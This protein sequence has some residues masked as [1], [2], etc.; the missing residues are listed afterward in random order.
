MFVIK[1]IGHSKEKKKEHGGLLTELSSFI[2]TANS[3]PKRWW[4]FYS[5]CSQTWVQVTLFMTYSTMNFPSSNFLVIVL[6]FSFHSWCWTNSPSVK[7]QTVWVFLPSAV[8]SSNF[9]SRLQ[10][11]YT[12]CKV[13]TV[14][15]VR[16]LPEEE[17][18]LSGLAVAPTFCR[19]IPTLTSFNAFALH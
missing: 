11:N 19:A 14:F 3:C 10:E 16:C 8:V 7:L 2:L 18:I 17:M 6:S 13:L 12:I 9:P 4:Y 5:T 15:M 1:R